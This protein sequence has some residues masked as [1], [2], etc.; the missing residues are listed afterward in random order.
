MEMIVY[1]GLLAIIMVG[2]VFS[3]YSVLISVETRNQTQ[4][5]N[6]ETN[7]QNN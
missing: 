1:I 3:A 2:S 7:V 4:H 5:I 6:N